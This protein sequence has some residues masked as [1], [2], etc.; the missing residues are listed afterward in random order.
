MVDNSPEKPW[1]TEEDRDLWEEE[2]RRLDREWYNID[3]GESY[4][5]NKLIKNSISKFNSF[6]HFQ[7][8]MKNAIHLEAQITQI[9]ENSN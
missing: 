6:I 8:T 2:Q 7:D 1:K 4:F 5:L 3:E 9:V